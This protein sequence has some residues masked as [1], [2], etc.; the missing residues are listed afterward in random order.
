M[1]TL[2]G[3]K[4]LSLDELF[5]LDLPPL[6]YVVDGMLPLGHA[7]LLT[8][9]EKAGKGLLAIDLCASVALGEPFLGRA[10]MQGPA[11]YCAVE[12][13]IRDMRDRIAARVGNHRDAPLS[14][15]PLDG[16]M[17]TGST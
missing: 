12:E 3:F 10:T 4:P 15:L 16:S 14:V 17:G 9:R 2:P 1:S 11:I 5:A 6:E 13:H 8:A 7:C